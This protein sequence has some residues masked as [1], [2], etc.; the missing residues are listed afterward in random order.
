MAYCRLGSGALGALLVMSLSVPAGATAVAAQDGTAPAAQDEAGTVTGVSLAAT[1][2]APTATVR[3]TRVRRTETKNWVP[4]SSDPSD[5]TFIPGRG[6]LVSDAEVEEEHL[7]PRPDPI[8]DGST[9]LWTTALTGVQ[10]PVGSTGSTLGYSNEPS[11]LT[12]V[13]NPTN[14]TND[15]LLVADD[16]PGL[17]FTVRRGAD[18][19]LG[20]SDDTAT[21]F[22]VDVPGVTNEDPESVAVDTSVTPNQLYIA[23]AMSAEVYQFRPGGAFVTSWDVAQFG[24]RHPEGITYDAARD[25]LLLLDD[26]SCRV[27]ELTKTGQLVNVIDITHGKCTHAAGIA[28]APASGGSGRS[29]YVVDRG[30]D[31]DTHNM[32]PVTDPPTLTGQNDGLLEEFSVNL[33]PLVDAGADAGVTHPAPVNL[34]GTARDAEP[35]AL[36]WVKHSGPGSVT[37]ASPNASTTTA[38]FSLPGTYVLRLQ[39]SDGQLSASDTVTV[40]SNGVPVVNAGADQSITL[41][42]TATLS[43]VVTDD[44]LPNPPATVSAQWSK[45]S[46]PGTVT[47]GNAANR[48]TSASFSAPG[49][50]VLRLTANDSGA[51]A[52]ADDVSVTVVAAPPPA[53][54]PPAVVPP[55]AQTPPP[56]PVSGQPPVTNPPSGPGP[57]LHAVTGSRILDTRRGVGARR[58]LLRPGK[59][60]A[61]QVEGRGGIP[62]AG[63]DSAR[64]RLTVLEPQGRGYLTVWPAKTDRPATTTLRFKRGGTVSRLVEAVVGSNG[65]VRIYNGSARPVHVLA[66]TKAWRGAG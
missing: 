5:I 33:H 66:V 35:L 61:L 10:V 1:A 28:I 21:S 27:Y 12:Y 15:A 19:T 25:T 14:P 40:V 55:P 9:N 8:F 46:G 37:F 51:P 39:G 58:G 3:A 30:L 31:N 48:A 43:G 6:L 50:Y 49:T 44:G 36:S 38:T 63:V 26:P 60:L 18:G 2:A 7:F 13:P 57:T 23:D 34:R 32:P 16:D 65:K 29:M 42:A 59:S 20:T 47:F 22:A 54:V 56:P 62:G 17:L 45:V 24:V 52:V 4:S 64:L 53:V 11:G 41:P